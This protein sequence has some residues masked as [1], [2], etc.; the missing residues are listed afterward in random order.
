MDDQ[1]VIG[2]PGKNEKQEL[3]DRLQREN[4]DVARLVAQRDQLAASANPTNLELISWS[5]RLPL[6]REAWGEGPT[7]LAESERLYA[8]ITEGE[9]ALGILPPE[10]E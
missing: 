1:P 6:L 3:L 2:T 4:D 5:L 8:L 9:R 10:G 7:D